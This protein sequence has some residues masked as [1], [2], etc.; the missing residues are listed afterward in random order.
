VKENV[1]ILKAKKLHKL[2]DLQL[3]RFACTNETAEASS[4]EQA[5]GGLLP[6]LGLRRICSHYFEHNST[7][8]KH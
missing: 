6:Q 4:Q 3:Y 7:L 1:A 5:V 2:V 8:C